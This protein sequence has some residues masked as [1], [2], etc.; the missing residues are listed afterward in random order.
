MKK[1]LG[2]VTVLF[3]ITAALVFSAWAVVILLGLL[4]FQAF[5]LNFAAIVAMMPIGIYKTEILALALMAFGY[6]F[7]AVLK[8]VSLVND[9]VAPGVPCIIADLAQVAV[10]AWMVY[11]RGI[12]N[13][14]LA[15]LIILGL[16]L[17]CDVASTVELDLL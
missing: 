3:Y 17:A 16:V 6:G 11:A 4:G 12:T 2:A 5:G 9:E 13:P 8:I 10:V 7:L 1:L 15:A 14:L